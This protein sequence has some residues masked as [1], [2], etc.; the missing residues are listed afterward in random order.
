M[1]MQLNYEE[2]KRPVN[3]QKD[4]HLFQSDKITPLFLW[5]LYTSETIKFTP[6][7]PITIQQH[8]LF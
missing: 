1:H 8:T 7:I 5:H 6:I 2:I 4:A 3:I